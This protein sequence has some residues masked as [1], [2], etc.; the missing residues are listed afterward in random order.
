MLSKILK[1]KLQDGVIT[2]SREDYEGSV[3]IDENLMRSMGLVEYE[4]VEINSLEFD[5]RHRTYVIPG[6]PG[7]KCVSVRGALAQYFKEGDR[8]HINCFCYMTA[9]EAA[10]FTPKIVKTNIWTSSHE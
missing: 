3:M 10:S 7:S 9:D 2:E 1:S 5:A 6:L 8:I 4:A